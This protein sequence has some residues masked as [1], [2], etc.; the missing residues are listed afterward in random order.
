MSPCASQLSSW[1]RVSAAV[2]HLMS[3]CCREKK[4]ISS[5]SLEGWV[6]VCKMMMMTMEERAL[7]NIK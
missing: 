1:W 6:E 2:A 3:R 5:F 4:G 7:R